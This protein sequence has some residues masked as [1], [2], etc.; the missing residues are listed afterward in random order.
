MESRC[1]SVR[2]VLCLDGGGPWGVVSRVPD[3]GERPL[4]APSTG[5]HTTLRTEDSGKTGLV[6]LEPI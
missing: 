2:L 6:Y 3:P 1:L 4:P 5:T